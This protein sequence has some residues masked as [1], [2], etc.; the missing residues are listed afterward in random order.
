VLAAVQIRGKRIA[1]ALEA[2]YGYDGTS[3][4]QHNGPGADQEVWHY[5]LHVFPRYRGDALYARTMERRDTVPAE[6]EPYAQKPRG[7]LHST[8]NVCECSWPAEV[9]A[10]TRLPVSS[11]AHGTP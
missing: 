8:G 5:H 6:R 1:L 2:T 11:S 10:T 3:F 4:R 9:F 7:H